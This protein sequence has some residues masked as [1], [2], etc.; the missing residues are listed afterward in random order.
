MKLGTT[1][2]RLLVGL[3]AILVALSGQAV[4]S[5]APLSVPSAKVGK[6]YLNDPGEVGGERAGSVF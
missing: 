1:R 5:A 4:A 6:D 2:A 3:G